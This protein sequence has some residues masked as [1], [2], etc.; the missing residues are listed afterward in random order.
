MSCNCQHHAGPPHDCNHINHVFD[1]KPPTFYGTWNHLYGQDITNKVSVS[2]PGIQ[3]GLY[4]NCGPLNCSCCG[5]V[6]MLT[7]VE[8]S[9]KLI[10]T[11]H[12]TYSDSKMN[13]SIDIEPG[14][15]YTIDY[16]NEGELCQC[17]GLVSNIYKISQLDDT[18]NIYK[19]NVDCSTQYSHKVVVIKSDQ[20]RGIAKYIPYYGEDTAMESAWHLYGTTVAYKIINAVVI[21]A[22]LDKNK[23]LVKGILVQGTIQNG[24]TTKGICVGENSLKHNLIISEPCSTGGN[25]LEG[26]IINGVVSSGDIDGETEDDTGYIVRA[27]IKGTLRDVLVVDTK[28]SNT[29]VASGTGSLITPVIENSRVLNATVSGE[30]MITTGGVTV[31]NV[32]MNGITT[33]GIAKGG[34]AIGQIDGKD[35]TLIGGTTVAQEGSVL[36]TEGGIVVGG[37]IIGGSRIGNSIYGATVKGGIL[38][39]GVTTGGNTSADITTSTINAF[40]QNNDPYNTSIP[41]MIPGTYITENNNVIP[42]KYD[43]VT[44][45]DKGYNDWYR[46]KINY[47]LNRMG[48]TNLVLATNEID[49][50]RLDHNLSSLIV[51]NSDI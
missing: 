31:G 3:S 50:S 36:Q 22:E 1:P 37:T 14:K 15:I 17:T 29:F 41:V 42:T 19:I 12:L 6:T 32:T 24:T 4:R 46:R 33:G 2:Q 23:N 35:F 20:I 25:I 47:P 10:L 21:N 38:T 40:I 34:V 44:A 8:T 11:V 45:V 30:D 9:A 26:F 28:I 43:A 48:D 7:G 13:T 27:T 49:Y 16:L 18:T 51:D 5:R 39:K